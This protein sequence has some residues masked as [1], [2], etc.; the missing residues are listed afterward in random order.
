MSN[1]ISVLLPHDLPEDWTDSKYVSPGGVEVGLT[2][3][4]G[5]N[6]LSQQINNAQIAA[7]ELAETLSSGIDNL[8]DNWYLAD[9][10]NRSG[11]YCVQAGT[12]YYSDEDLEV[13]AGVLT[14][15]S[16]VPFVNDDWGRI[17]RNG[18][19][20]YVP[21]LDVYR[22]YVIPATGAYGFDRWW[23]K[24]AVIS[25]VKSSTEG[26]TF[27]PQATNTL[28]S[29]RQAIPN[30]GR[31]AGRTVTLSA[32]VTYSGGYSNI[33]LYKANAVGAAAPIEI[34][35]K[36][37]FKGINTLTAVIP[38][39]VGGTTYPYLLVGIET[40]SD[41]GVTI[42]AIKLQLGSR[43]T[44]AYQDA[45]NNW[46]LRDIPN[47]VIE[48]VRC[49]GAPTDIGGQGMIVVPEDIGLSTANVLAET[50]VVE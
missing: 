22:G 41:T 46:L 49:N 33:K 20:Y 26:L 18:V 21:L 5:Y 2:P 1:F 17:T 7:V 23:A 11:G 38:S 9:P 4:H 19:Q 12:E 30:P 15:P 29:V 31:L 16:N 28:A 34:A 3:K 50:E 45:S 8:L 13:P 47:K 32:L 42:T 43:Q 14:S 35:T 36:A 10:V 40:S 44:L 37:L 27:L 39:D 25:K 48:T 6:Y 24:S